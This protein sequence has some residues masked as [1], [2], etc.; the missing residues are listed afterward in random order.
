[1]SV[2]AYCYCVS[3]AVSVSVLLYDARVWCMRKGGGG[4]GRL[5][6]ERFVD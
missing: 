4:K 5:T 2:A 1:M 6:D 3:V